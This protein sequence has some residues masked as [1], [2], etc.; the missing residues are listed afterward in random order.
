MFSEDWKTFHRL[1]TIKLWKNLLQLLLNNCY[2]L[3]ILTCPLLAGNMV[4]L[5]KKNAGSVIIQRA[6]IP[7]SWF[8]I[9]SQIYALEESTYP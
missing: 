1:I 6:V 2:S 8:L 7:P 3:L 5:L 9:F 4:N